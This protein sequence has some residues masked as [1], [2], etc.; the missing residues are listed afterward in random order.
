MATKLPATIV[1]PR[2]VADAV[3]TAQRECKDSY[4]QAYLEALPIA[5]EEYGAKGILVQLL[6]ALNNMSTWRGE[7]A[8]ATKATLR[9]FVAQ[10]ERRV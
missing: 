3:A 2:E 5:A 4:A 1:T 8:R 10:R 9:A 6:Y 7:T